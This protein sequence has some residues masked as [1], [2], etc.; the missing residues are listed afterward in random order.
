[1]EEGK[2]GG[3]LGENRGKAEGKNFYKKSLT[4]S[5]GVPLLPFPTLIQVHAGDANFPAILFNGEPFPCFPI[6]NCA[7]GY[8]GVFGRIGSGKVLSAVTEL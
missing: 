4:G 5:A 6:L 2:A 7:L 1:M 3:R 8:V